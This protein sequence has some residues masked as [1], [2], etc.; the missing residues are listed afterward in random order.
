MC[1]LCISEHFVNAAM[2]RE[3]AL[4]GYHTATTYGRPNLQ[5]GGVAVF[6]RDDDF[7]ALDRINCLSVEL[8]CE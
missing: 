2:C 4:E 1:I 5:Q 6:S 3:I 7:T 8:H